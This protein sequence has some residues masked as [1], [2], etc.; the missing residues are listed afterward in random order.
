MKP[1]HSLAAAAAVFALAAGAFAGSAA[2]ELKLRMSVE[3]TP[4]APT[5]Y[6]LGAFRDALQEEMGDDVEIEYFDS[7]TLGDEIVH[8]EQVRTGQLDVYPLGSDAVTLDSKWAVFDMPFLFPDRDTV[9]R[10]LD[11]EV[12]QELDQ[13][14]QSSAGLKVLGLG[15]LGFRQITNNVRPIVTPDDL[16]GLKIRVPGSQTRIAAFQAFGANPLTMNIGELYLAMQQGVVDG[17]ENPLSNVRAWSWY[18]VQRYLSMSNHVYT[19]V[20]LV[21]NLRRYESLTD[22]ERAAV[23]RAAARAVEA[24]RRYGEEND[25]KLIEEIRELS[26]GNMEFNDIDLAAFKAASQEVVPIIAQ[27]AGQEFTDKVLGAVGN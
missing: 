21:M 19:P 16:R 13:S 10:V 27:A 24:S 15:E 17:Q 18:E 22:D 1:V 4:G 5:Q 3:S 26:G 8:M 25:A 12:G 2:A 6:I 14:M 9:A 23:D 11:G 7:G 20:T